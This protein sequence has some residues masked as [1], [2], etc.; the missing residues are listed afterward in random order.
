MARTKQYA[1]RVNILK[2]VRVGQGFGNSLPFLNETERSSATTFSFL[3]MMNTILKGV[4][5]W[6][7][8]RRE[9]EGAKRIADFSEVV[10][11]AR[12][13]SIEVNAQKAGIIEAGPEP[14][15]QRVTIS[16]AIDEYLDFIKAHRKERT[17][18][19]YRYTLDKL[20]RAMVSQIICGPD[21]TRRHLAVHDRL[22]Q[23]R[24]G[25]RTVYDKLVVVLQLFKRYGKIKLIEPS[26]WPHYVETIR[27]IYEADEIG[28]MLEHADP[29]EALFLKFL[30]ASGFRDREVRR[31]C[32]ARPH[33]GA[34][35]STG[36]GANIN[37]QLGGFLG[38]F[39]LDFGHRSAHLDRMA[40]VLHHGYR[41]REAK[42]RT[43]TQPA[44]NGDLPS[45]RLD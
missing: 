7:G 38:L 3:A 20:L 31:C 14:E 22:L 19:T 25:K 21:H 1:E 12:R 44:L 24:F 39:E 32:L 41:N 11:A 28:A 10:E 26:D 23:T 18:V 42:S 34:P 40:D 2:K 16:Q 13:K 29:D 6:S 30:L 45:Q 35:R 36:R 9:G 27:P 15:Q 37:A 4:T 43:V 33:S 8:I 5:T 17:Y